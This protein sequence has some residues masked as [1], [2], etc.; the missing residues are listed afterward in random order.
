MRV[1][2]L[3]P[4][5]DLRAPCHW[6]PRCISPFNRR[7]LG[8]IYL[9]K[10]G[11]LSADLNISSFPSKILD[12]LIMKSEAY[13]C[14]C[15]YFSS[16]QGPISRVGSPSSFSVFSGSMLATHILPG[17]ATVWLYPSIYRSEP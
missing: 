15:R 7:V 9:I 16:P 1:T 10:I 4:R 3:A 5:T 6:I 11:S 14:T 8:H 13:S 2:V 12:L 17:H